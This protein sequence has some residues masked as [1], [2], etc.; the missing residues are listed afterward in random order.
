[1]T[2]FNSQ[3][4]EEADEYVKALTVW[5]DFS[6]HSLTKRLT[7]LLKL[8]LIFFHFSTHSLTKRLTDLKILYLSDSLFSTHSL[9]KRLTFLLKLKLIFFHFSTHSLTKRLTDGKEEFAISYPFQLTA[10]RRG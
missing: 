1:M 7:F 4:H 2:F 9:T 5:L 3:P 10:S 6:T 8:K